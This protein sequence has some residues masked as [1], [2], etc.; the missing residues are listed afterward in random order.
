MLK[1]SPTHTDSGRGKKAVAKSD[2][3]FDPAPKLS[4]LGISKTQ[5][6]RWQMLAD[7]KPDEFE[8][9][10]ERA[11]RKAVSVVNGTAREVIREAERAKY[12]Q[13]KRVGGTVSG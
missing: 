13:L 6:S 2:R 7:L 1:H 10:V 4:D 3:F 8:T 5:S 9:N 12:A 11:K